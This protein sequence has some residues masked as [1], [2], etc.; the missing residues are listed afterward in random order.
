MLARRHDARSTGLAAREAFRGV[1]YW[2]IQA[3]GFTV[4]DITRYV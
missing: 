1:L 3:Q 2:H 4:A